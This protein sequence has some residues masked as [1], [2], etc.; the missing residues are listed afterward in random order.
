MKKGI[1]KEFVDIFLNE[2]LQL[3]RVVAEIKCWMKLVLIVNLDN[4]SHNSLHAPT[5]CSTL[6]KDLRAGKWVPPITGI[7]I[8][9]T[10]K[11]DHTIFV[12]IIDIYDIV[13]YEETQK[14][15]LAFVKLSVL[16]FF[17]V[18]VN[19]FEEAFIGRLEA[20]VVTLWEGDI[21]MDAVSILSFSQSKDTKPVTLVKAKLRWHGFLVG[22][23]VAGHMGHN[24]C[25]QV[26]FI[27]GSWHIKSPRT[28]HV[29]RRC[30]PALGR[31]GKSVS[32]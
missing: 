22:L 32:V 29:R 18:F 5:C 4:I 6:L 11:R 27:V 1:S 20:L 13:S 2:L 10:Y 23:R 8:G 28:G 21:R 24:R 17:H 12:R 7:K 25:I 9:M 19:G 15:Q 16:N 30:I 3:R 31:L 26:T 14:R